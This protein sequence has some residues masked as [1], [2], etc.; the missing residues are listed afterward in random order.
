MNTLHKLGE[1]RYFW[2]TGII[3]LTLMEAIALY[4]Q[5]GPGM[6]Y[7]CALCVQVRAWVMGSLIFSVMGAILA[8]N[9]WWR[10]MSLNLTIVLM[11][12]ALYTSYYA[13][14]VEQGTVI[15]SCTMGAGFPEFMPLD[16][17][18][19]VLFEAQGM[20]GQSPPMPLGVSMVEA[21]LITLS[22]PLLVLVAVWVSHVQKIIA[23]ETD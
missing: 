19:P 23:H 15:S 1:S 18:V 3:Y 22:I 13:F 16:Q 2:L 10:W 12:G 11:A 5:Y 6:W 14:G 4:Y 9:F 8:K 20:C 17:W 21:L 7:P